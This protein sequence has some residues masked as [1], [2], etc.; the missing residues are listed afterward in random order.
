MAKQT[1]TRQRKIS[2]TNPQQKQFEKLLLELTSLPTAA[3]CEHAVFRYLY[4][5]AAKRPWIAIKHDKWGNMLFRVKGQKQ[6]RN[7]PPLFIT[8]HLDHPA[9]VV[10]N[11]KD[12]GRLVR[13]AFRGGVH[14][15]FFIETH[16]RWWPHAHEQSVQKLPRTPFNAKDSFSA[17]MDA[18]Q[19]LRGK[20]IDLNT[21]QSKTSHGDKETTIQFARKNNIKAGDIITWDLPAS[22][23]V[24]GKLHARVCDDLA[25]T[26]ASLAAFDRWYARNKKQLA[27]AANVQLLFTRSEEIGFI[28]AIGACQS[29]LIPKPSRI[30]AL[31]N[32]K[33]FVHDSPQGAGPIIRVGDRI[34][35]FNHELNMRISEIAEQM[36]QKD[37]AFKYQRKLM[38]GGACEATAYQC[39]GYQ[40]TCL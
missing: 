11:V 8:S 34:S 21:D 15:T 4:H 16:V 20:I 23:I 13:A 33:S 26:A 37:Q 28:G 1:Q 12:G 5:W 19:G 18:K 24:R 7:R 2:F 3:G 32:S 22:R 17:L 36:T 40:A 9:F 35:T 38:P 27:T 39:F 30:I 10:Q 14:N 6:T 31:E 29:G 25:A